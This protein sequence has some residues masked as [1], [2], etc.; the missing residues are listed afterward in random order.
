[1]SVTVRLGMSRV[2]LCDKVGEVFRELSHARHYG[3]EQ[4]QGETAVEDALHRVG[5]LKD[6]GAF[7]K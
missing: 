7:V 3:P 6:A 1:M 4:D 2:A 5:N